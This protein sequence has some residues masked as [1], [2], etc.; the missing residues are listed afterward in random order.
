M[1]AVRG[2]TTPLVGK[3]DQVCGRIIGYQISSTDTF[4]AGSGR[5]IDTSYADGISVTRG[6]PRQHTWTFAAGLDEG[7]SF[8]AATC[9]CVSGSTASTHIPSFV[10]QNYFCKTAISEWN[11]FNGDHA[12]TGICRLVCSL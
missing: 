8:S 12:V 7:T 6:S 2:S 3:F 4:L 5:S 10:G 11:G 9:P 1:V